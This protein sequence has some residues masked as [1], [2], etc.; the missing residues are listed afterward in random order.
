MISSDSW[1][2]P[3]LLRIRLTLWRLEAKGESSLTVVGVRV[4]AVI[5]L[6]TFRGRSKIR[7]GTVFTLLLCRGGYW[8][9][10]VLSWPL[11]LLVCMF[12]GACK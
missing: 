7:G 10:R 9:V 4:G 8:V 6:G 2:Q 11:L 12:E 5:C 3:R 1:T